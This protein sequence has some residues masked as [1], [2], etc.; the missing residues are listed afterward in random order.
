M[1]VPNDQP[2][3][4]EERDYEVDTT[5]ET[6][7]PQTVTMITQRWTLLQAVGG[8]EAVQPV[9][10]VISVA[11]AVVIAY[12]TM[13]T[14]G[15]ASITQ[16]VANKVPNLDNVQTRTSSLETSLASVLPRINTIADDIARLQAAL[17]GVVGEA[18]VDS[19]AQD[20]AR[21]KAKDN[22]PATYVNYR[23]DDFLV[24][25]PTADDTTYSGYTCLISE[26]LR[27]DA[28]AENVVQL[29]TY[30]PNDP[31]AKTSAGGIVLPTYET[32]VQRIVADGSSYLS[33]TQYAFQTTSLVQATMSATRVRYGAEF[34]AAANDSFFAG[35]QFIG[36]NN[37]IA[38]TFE[39]SGQTF[40]IYDTD[41]VNPDGQEIY[42]VANYWAD[43]VS[44]PYWQRTPVTGSALGYAWAQ[45]FVQA[46]SGWCVGMTPR[47][48][49]KPSSG[50]I[51]FGICATSNGQPD[52]SNILAQVT[53]QAPDVVAIAQ[54]GNWIIPLEPTFL[55][56][57]QRYAYFVLTQAAYSHECAD[58]EDNA[59]GTCFYMINGGIWY[60]NPSQNLTFDLAFA[61]FQQSQVSITMQPL[62]LSGGIAAID[63][64]ANAIVPANTF[65][66]YEI[67]VN[68]QWVTLGPTDVSALASLPPLVQFRVT[69]VGTA[70]LMPGITI[71]GSQCTVSRPKTTLKR[72]SKPET[73]ASAATKLSMKTT[74][75]DFNAAHH[76]YAAKAN[77]A[78]TV[79]TADTTTD[80]VIDSRTI[81]R[82]QVFNIGSSFTSYVSEQDGTTDSAAL[83][84]HAS[85]I[86]EYAQ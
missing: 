80:V 24:F 37:G 75:V 42:R 9:A 14:A 3:D 70:Y 8:V 15:I 53:L 55:Q 85:S 17:A 32:T 35:G 78:G 58:I 77:L 82:T 61:S 4:A 67:F 11:A 6:Y 10:P 60:P 81:E 59:G 19:L 1:A 48:A 73:L 64:I 36:N 25:D 20:V 84:F 62:Q 51:T 83:L 23:E 46:Q 68:G 5:T 72:G 2:T 34:E 12:V 28:D 56:A 38:A 29:Q 13:T 47:I 31:N 76:T 41:Q 50:A 69:M 63:I 65:L 26:G 44:S 7:E 52:L 71:A 43:T 16:V 57:G 33:L 79:H 40:Q 45:S 30:N 39:K 74:L 54:V 18:T 66:N 49:I 86:F 27:F 22:L 21:L